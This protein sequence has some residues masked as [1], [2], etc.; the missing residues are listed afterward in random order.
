[1]DFLKLLKSFKDFVGT[2]ITFLK[3]NDA[4]IQKNSKLSMNYNFEKKFGG[5]SLCTSGA[6]GF[7][8]MHIF[9]ST[10]FD[11]ISIFELSKDQTFR[12]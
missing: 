2:Y 6:A 7:R 9:S 11:E 8:A 12:I 4:G 5:G 10:Y 1:M 3:G